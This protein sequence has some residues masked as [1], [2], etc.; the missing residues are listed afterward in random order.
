MKYDYCL[1]ARKSTED[2]EKQALSIESQVKEMLAIAERDELNVVDIKRESHSAKDS[3]ERPVFNELIQGLKDDE[4]QGIITWATDRLSRNAGDL[5]IIVDLIDKNYLVEI[6][7]YGQVF[8]NSPNDKFLLM[9]LG[10][11]A[12]LENDNKAV[13]VKRGMRAKCE[14]GVRPC[15]TPLGYLNDPFHAKGLKEITLDPERAPIIKKM[16]EKSASGISGRKILDWADSIGFKTRTGKR[17]S[18]NGL[19]GL[20]GNT[21]YYG[22]FEWPSGSGTWY[23]V[24]HESIITKKLF[25]KVQNRFNA[26]SKGQYG[27]KEFDFTGTMKCGECGSSIIATKKTKIL[28]D[29]TKKSYT[30]YMCS[31]YSHRHC[32][33]Y[34]IREEDLVPQLI[35]LMDRVD[36]DKFHLR[37]EYEYEVKRFHQFSDQLGKDYK[38]EAT[39]HIDVRS[40]MKYVLEQGSREE[41]KRML[42][43]LGANICL[44]DKKAII[45][46]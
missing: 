35:E 7:T 2:D 29:G 15:Q 21:Y 42:K 8:T 10:S 23:K 45:E 39:D 27:S 6:R 46:Y 44:K 9:I 11:Q 1:Y 40:Q 4:Y 37:Q 5:G 12:K 36:L 14:M 3:G 33:E 20:L 34:P 17:L 32:K 38:K 30:Y 26:M 19:F 24:N 31:R 13:N 16:F 18:P 41:K 43:N 22:E 28:S 25:D